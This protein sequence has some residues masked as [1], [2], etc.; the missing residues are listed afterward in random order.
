MAQEPR[1]QGAR[2]CII[3]VDGDEA[4]R[5]R[6]V[7]ALR[8]GGMDALGATDAASVRGLMDVRPCDLVAT[9]LDLPDGNGLMLIR[10]LRAASAI[11]LIALTARTEVVDRIVAL[12][13]GADDYVTK[14]FEPRELAVRCR[15]LMWRV[16]TAGTAA[17]FRGADR[18]RFADWVF[19]HGKRLL[20]GADEQPVM[21]T[22]QEAAVLKALVDN[23]GRVM[24]RDALMDAVGRGWNPTDRTVDVLIGRLRKKIE[25]NPAHPELIVTVYGE[26]YMFGELP[27]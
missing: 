12:E 2:R 7:S 21:L 9:E 15:N 6:A 25:P 19:D 11:G 10:D 26:G 5:E 24:S 3:V 13:M 1:K 23:P 17:V 27:Y 20:I 8:D 18:V 16:S 22:R 14:P 4:A